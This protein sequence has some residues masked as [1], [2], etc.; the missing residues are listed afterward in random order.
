MSVISG[1][2]A[3]DYND[4]TVVGLRALQVE[5]YLSV[6]VFSNSDPDYTVQQNSA[7]FSV[8][9]LDTA[10]AFSAA[11]TENQVMTT[12]G[13]HEMTGY[14]TTGCARISKCAC[15][16][17]LSSKHAQTTGIADCS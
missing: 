1:G 15:S 16:G 14:S 9:A 3:S 7:G 4:M 5:D 2:L 17:T 6:N 12:I 13:W 10:V 8:C 11:K